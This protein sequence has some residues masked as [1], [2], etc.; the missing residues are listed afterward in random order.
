MSMKD[1]LLAKKKKRVAQKQD[2]LV[3]KLTLVNE[4]LRQLDPSTE[5][6]ILP[7]SRFTDEYRE[8]LMRQEGDSDTDTGNGV[9]KENQ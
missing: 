4:E 8:F 6:I 1:W 5:E 3:R 7:P 2:R 9:K